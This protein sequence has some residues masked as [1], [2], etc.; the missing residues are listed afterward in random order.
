[1]PVQLSR[2]AAINQGLLPNVYGKKLFYSSDFWLLC[3]ILS[4]CLFYRLN[5]RFHADSYLCSKRD[6]VDVY[7][8]F[9]QSKVV[10]DRRTDINNVGSM[11]QALYFS[12][13]NKGTDPIEAAGWQASQV[14]TLSLMNFSGRIFIGMLFP[15]LSPF[16]FFNS[17]LH[18]HH[19]PR[20][21]HF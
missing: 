10:I 3:S 7:V 6:W 14:S 4:L 17:Q 21:G 20:V 11:A 16:F 1:V 15:L 19:R 9:L 8:P 18:S 2:R 12:G 13:R 5:A